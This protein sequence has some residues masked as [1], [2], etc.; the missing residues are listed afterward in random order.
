MKE[1]NNTDTN[2]GETV[3][4]GIIGAGKAGCSLGM[5][6]KNKCGDVKLPD[7]KMLRLSGYYSLHKSSAGE[8]AERTGSRC[9]SS[10]E[11]LVKASDVCVITVPDGQISS[12]WH[13]IR[14][15]DIRN[16]VIIHMS[17]SI[18]AA[19][20]DG[21]EETGACGYSLHP[22]YAI[23]S[24]YE[25]Y[26][27]FSNA[28]FT[29]EGNEKYMVYIKT[30]ADTV[31]G[32]CVCID[33]SNKALYH[34]ASVFASNLVVGLFETASEMLVKCGFNKEQA[35]KALGPLFTGNA[36]K[37]AEL[38]TEAALTG[39][40]ERNDIATVEKHLAVLDDEEKQIYTSLSGQILKVAERKNP[41]RDYSELEKL[42]KK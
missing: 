35:V 17:G 23:S 42:L 15:Y 32:G 8:A 25:S 40:V 36:L 10:M 16:R 38:G 1:Y 33:G 29:L 14:N 4:V 13:D 26:Q 11:E 2:F 31:T 20:F 39:P 24:K 30:F 21:I 28:F 7:K 41:D 34:G 27:G 6:I 37:I 19:V 12:V 22:M 18:S 9:Y 5:F 3:S